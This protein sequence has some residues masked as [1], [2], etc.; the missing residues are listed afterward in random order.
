MTQ[1]KIALEDVLNAVMLEEKDPNYKTLLRW[2]KRYPEY[3]ED[4]A[5][6]FAS[7]AIQMDIPVDTE[8]DESHLANLGVSRALNILHRQKEASSKTTINEPQAARLL[9]A[10]R[11]VGLSDEALANK[12][13]LDAGII[14]KLDL[15]RLSDIPD[16]CVQR[17]AEVLHRP[18]PFVRP[19]IT[20]P[21]IVDR[22]VRYRAV[23]RP[24]PKTEDFAAAVRSSTLSRIQ[25][26]FWLEVVRKQRERADR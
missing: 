10:C 21:P 16:L 11:Q 25:Q 8:I 22:R 19:L 12:I 2:S 13:G 20:G 7:W 18:I 3:R 14:T 26:D 17:I 23:R 15:R 9:I 5:H 6:F 1:L 4:L 24:E